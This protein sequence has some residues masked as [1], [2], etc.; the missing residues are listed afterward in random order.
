LWRDFDFDFEVDLELVLTTAFAPG[1]A[2]GSGKQSV[3]INNAV[4]IDFPKSLIIQPL[5]LEQLSA[6]L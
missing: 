1:S 3:E 2:A 5:T 4:R 6:L